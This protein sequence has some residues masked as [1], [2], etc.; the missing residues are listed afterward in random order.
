M[1]NTSA[2]RF[3]EVADAAIVLLRGEPYPPAERKATQIDSEV[4]DRYVG[5]YETINDVFTITR[6]GAAL[7]IQNNKNPKKGELFAETQT[8]FFL[9]GDPATVSFEANQ[10][11][12][13]DQMVITPP[14]WLISVAK[15]RK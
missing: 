13:V 14:D 12:V 7:F 11:G 8:M 1:T 6:E 10:E 2:D 5:I 4:L 9:K 15:R 3:Q